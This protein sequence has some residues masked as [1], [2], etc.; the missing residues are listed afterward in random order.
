MNVQ[1]L[2]ETLSKQI[3]LLRDGKAEPKNVNAIVNA[4]GKVLS[5]IRLEMEYARM[6]GVIPRIS[7]FK[8]LPNRKE[9]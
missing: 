6:L 8:Q 9:A 2:R 3:I 1:E 4:A 7:A 5:S